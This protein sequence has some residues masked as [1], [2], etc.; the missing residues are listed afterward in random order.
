MAGIGGTNHSGRVFESTLVQ[1]KC[2]EALANDKGK[3]VE[4]IDQGKS[5]MK[6]TVSDKDVGEFLRLIK[7]SD[8]RVVDQ[9]NQTPSKISITSLLLSS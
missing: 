8:Y 5:S 6:G 1:Q 2:G 7:K 9:L 3:V 4:N